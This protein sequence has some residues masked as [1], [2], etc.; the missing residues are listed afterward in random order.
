MRVWTDSRLPP[1]V[2]LVSALILR[3]SNEAEETS[4]RRK[5][6]LMHGMPTSSRVGVETELQLQV[7]EL[8]LVNE[9]ELRRATS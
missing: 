9:S 6:D 8:P 5:G 2:P 7:W 4:R 3:V 1:A